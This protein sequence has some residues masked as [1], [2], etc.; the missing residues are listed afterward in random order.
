[1]GHTSSNFSREVKV[2]KTLIK[3]SADPDLSKYG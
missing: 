2:Y 1:M 3:Y